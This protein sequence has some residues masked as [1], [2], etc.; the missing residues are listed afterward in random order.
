MFDPK[1]MSVFIWPLTTILDGVA[2]KMALTI[3]A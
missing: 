3:S 1:S 2:I